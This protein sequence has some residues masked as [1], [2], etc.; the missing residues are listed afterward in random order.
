MEVRNK[1]ELARL[2]DHTI[3]NPAATPEDVKK[4]CEE[5]LSYGFW[6]V[7]VN[8]WYVSLAKSVL[9]N[10]AK[11]MAVVSFPFGA[12]KTSVKV[13]EAEEAIND[14]AD[15]IDMVMNIGAFKAGLYELV[16]RDV[17]AVVGLAHDYG[18]L[19]K[20]IIETGYLTPEEIIRA[21]QIAAKAGADFVKTSTG[22]GPRGATVEDVQLMHK[23]VG[24]QARIKAAG[25]IRA[26]EQALAMIKAGASRIGSSRGVDIIRTFPS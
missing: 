1:E 7:V 26:A 22:Y 21:S 23:A 15:E 19:V 14:G 25:G 17:R 4:Y 13:E 18:V 8:P 5:A 2:I 20:V 10:R 3:L 11:A 16:E 24:G 6:G 9:G 12:D